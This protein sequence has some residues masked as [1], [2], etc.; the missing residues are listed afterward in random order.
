LALDDFPKLENLNLSYN[1]IS[2]GSIR[3]LYAIKRLK[4]LDLSGNNLVTLP[5][6]M[7]EFSALEEL[8]L[9]SNMFASGSTIVNPGVLFKCLGQMSRLKKLNIS[10]N[11]FAALHSDF[12]IKD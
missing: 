5:E 4:V 6:D 1:S 3:H 9:S 2:P 12:L 10:R 11:R 8:N 7:Y